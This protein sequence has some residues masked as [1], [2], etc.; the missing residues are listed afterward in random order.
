MSDTST[1][2][3]D[4]E[5][6]V[7]EGDFVTGEFARQLEIELS[8]ANKRIHRLIVWGNELNDYVADPPER[9]C[10]CHICPPCCDC[11]DWADLREIKENWKEATE[12]KP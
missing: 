8:E 10:S 5:C 3:T 1:P 12:Q 2:R 7:N 11:V 6:F 9:N 4:A